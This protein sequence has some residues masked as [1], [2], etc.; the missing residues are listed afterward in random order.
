M[1][2]HFLR[3]VKMNKII[4]LSLL[5]LFLQ[6][7][8]MTSLQMMMCLE[9]IITRNFP[10]GQV[11]VFSLPSTASES[12]PRH[13]QLTHDV[14]DDI[15]FINSF[16]AKVN[17]RTKWPLVISTEPQNVDAVIPEPQHGYV[18]FLTPSEDI[19]DDLQIQ[20]DN[21]QTFGFSYNRRGKFV[22]VVLQQQ[23]E[24]S[25]LLSKEILTA[26]WETDNILD[27]V[28]LIR[29]S[30]H[31]QEGICNVYALFPFA[32][33]HCQQDKVLLVDQCTGDGV[34]E[35]SNTLPTR[36]VPSDMRGCPLRVNVWIIPPYTILTSNNTGN[37]TA[38]ITDVE[39][40]D[41]VFLNFIREAMNFS[42]E[43]H[44]ISVDYMVPLNSFME[45]GGIFIGKSSITPHFFSYFDLT[46]PYVF[47]HY[48]L[49]V[50]CAKPNPTSG[51][52]LAVFS[53]SVWLTSMAVLFLSAMVFW[54]FQKNCADSE[55]FGTYSACLLNAWAVFLSASVNCLPLRNKMRTFFLLFV[56]HCFALNTIFQSF[57]T[58]Y[59]IDPGY[60]KQI[61]SI[62]ELNEMQIPILRFPDGED[63]EHMWG[64]QLFMKFKKKL[65]CSDYADCTS[66]M[67]KYQNASIK[68]DERVL[69][70]VATKL[71]VQNKVLCPIMSVFTIAASIY[72]S[73]GDPLRESFNKIIQKCV[74]SGLANRYWSILTAKNLLSKGK[75]DSDSYTA[76]AFFHLQTSFL[77]L[78]IGHS[79]GVCLFILEIL[80]NKC[81]K[82]DAC[83]IVSSGGR[84]FGCANNV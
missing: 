43:L 26:I 58:S 33:E 17:D 78:L 64:F 24:D 49:F 44:S 51:N 81:L 57:F 53:S 83:S 30:G 9:E 12:E 61:E 73:K 13:L 35:K 37:E 3:T 79:V 54:Y 7:V 71:G 21:L 50:P 39:G 2:S 38:H 52:V 60:E 62:E 82:D 77:F 8:F 45:G 48:L 20:I 14:S 32:S 65:V 15:T 6:T 5:S 69:E 74:E 41:L 84:L 40:I 22:I 80:Y 42:I 18:I 72:L 55:T 75:Q 59:F 4:Q 47:T 23:I 16:I 68:E 67:I 70:Y 46:V 63:T 1:F 19:V 34:F 28:T 31:D 29:A 76:L 56:F 10:P 25:Y 27:S 36:K 66:Y 11:I